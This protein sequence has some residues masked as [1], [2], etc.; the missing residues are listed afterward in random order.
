M[1]G[2]PQFDEEREFDRWVQEVTDGWRMPPLAED[3]VAWQA[4]IVTPRSSGWGVALTT[5]RQAG[6]ALGAAAVF[7]IAL[8]VLAASLPIGPPAAPGN[9]QDTSARPTEHSTAEPPIANKDASAP[10]PQ[11]P[12]AEPPTTEPAKAEPPIAT[13]SDENFRITIQ[14]DKPRY[15]AD[16]PILITT[17]LAYIGTEAT[18]VTGAAG[19]LVGF[20]IEQLDGP[21]DAGGARDE[22]CVRYDFRRGDVESVEFQKSG[23]YSPDD[24]MADFWR[25]FYKDPRLRLPMGTYRI[26][27][28]AHYGPSECGETEQV[29]TS[30]VIEVVEPPTATDRDELFRIAIEADK[31][32]YQ[33]NEPI[34]VHATLEY[35]GQAE[36]TTITSAYDGPVYFGIEQLDGSI[37]MGPAMRTSCVTYR[38]RSGDRETIPFQKS[39]GFDGSDAL[40]DFWSSYFAEPQLRLPRGEYRIFVVVPYSLRTCGGEK[41]ELEASVIV[42]VE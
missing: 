15:E 16:E 32:R 34:S 3:P 26:T 1:T 35:I 30:I 41:H 23:A 33:V 40:A 8:I 19:G 29:A 28:Q 7:A 27:A 42:T 12:T 4:R 18:T 9:D 38:Y 2:H 6:G 21:I 5:R 17:S 24:P 22:A 13:E 37:D 20:V 36:A 11:Q 14:A 10:L 31:A 25:R 39:G